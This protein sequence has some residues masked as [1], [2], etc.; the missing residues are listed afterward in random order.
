[1]SRSANDVLNELMGK[2]VEVRSLRG[3]GECVDSGVLEAYDEQWIKLRKDGG[4][5]LYFSIAN[6]RL[7]KPEV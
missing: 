2:S 1:M 5:V 6:V 7:L 3:Q 4:E